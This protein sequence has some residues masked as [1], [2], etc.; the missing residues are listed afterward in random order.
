MRCATVLVVRVL[1]NCYSELIHPRNPDCS[2]GI[3][4]VNLPFSKN[5]CRQDAG[6]TSGETFSIAMPLP[7]ELRP[8]KS[9]LAKLECA[10]AASRA[11]SDAGAPGASVAAFHR[12]CLAGRRERD[13]RPA[14]SGVAARRR[15][16][17]RVRDPRGAG[18]ARRVLRGMH[19]LL[20]SRRAGV[21]CFP[22]R[23]TERFLAP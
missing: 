2:A 14:A 3:Q 23:L 16:F 13:A 5:A 11:A 22:L 6:A 19:E 17:S 15:R 21:A 18:A 8:A 7:R 4:P 1:A 20:R 10:P 9:G 12:K